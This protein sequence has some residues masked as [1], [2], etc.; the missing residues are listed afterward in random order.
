MGCGF[1]VS[2]TG[3]L[4]SFETI[5]LSTKNA[6][7][8]L[9]DVPVGVSEAGFTK[10]LCRRDAVVFEEVAKESRRPSFLRALAC[11]LVVR[12]VPIG[13]LAG[14][15][16]LGGRS[17][18]WC[19]IAARRVGSTRSTVVVVR[20]PLDLSCTVSISVK[21]GLVWRQKKPI[22]KR[23]PVASYVEGPSLTT[24]LRYQD[25]CLEIS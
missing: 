4:G 16:V 5:R 7:V 9:Y 25:S 24:S 15:V 13:A 23:F 14:A 21:R 2:P 18:R 20:A 3:S 19:A 10:K 1:G 11:V 22:V 17:W 12:F 6:C 8:S